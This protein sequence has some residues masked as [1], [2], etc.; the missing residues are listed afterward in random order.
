MCSNSTRMRHACVPDTGI[1][2]R[3]KETSEQYETPVIVPVC[4]SQEIRTSGIIL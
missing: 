3:K 4:A 1:Y 2:Q